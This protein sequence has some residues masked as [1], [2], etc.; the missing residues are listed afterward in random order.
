MKKKLQIF[1]S[2][3]FSDLQVERQSA[4]EAVLRAGHIPAGME[5]FSAGNE[6]QLE[7]IKRWIDESDVYMLIL[8]GRYGS[9]ES[10]SGLSYT[11]IEYNYALEKGKPVFAIVVSEDLLQEKV[12]KFGTEVIERKAV[13]KYD[14]F[15]E[16]VLSKICRFFNDNTE[17]KLSVFESLLDIQARF[18]LQGWV[19]AEEIPDLSILLQQIADLKKEND[20]FRKQAAIKE[21]T[22][23]PSFGALSFEDLSQLLSHKIVKIPAAVSNSAKDS[24]MSYLELLLANAGT[25]NSGIDSMSVGAAGPFMYKVASELMVFGLID[26]T[27]VKRGQITSSVLKTSNEGKRFIAEFEVRRHNAKMQKAKDAAPNGND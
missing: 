23:A 10:K 8:G 11:E 18:Q 21:K 9:I 1:I 15:K 27:S 16:N 22:N 2:S 6:S 14:K 26:Q 3:T 19:R 24:Q 13:D 20:S 7:I 12:K 17:I 4:V 25:F 5:L